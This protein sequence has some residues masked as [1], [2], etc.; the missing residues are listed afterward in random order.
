M[1]LL[2]NPHNI[3]LPQVGHIRRNEKTPK[4]R[5]LDGWLRTH[6]MESYNSTNSK[7]ETY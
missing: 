2:P 3:A 6:L 4:I 7:D 1:S 5:V